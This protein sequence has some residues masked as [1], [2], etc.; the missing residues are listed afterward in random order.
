MTK[1]EI[2]KM[3]EITMID[4]Y[5]MH[6]KRIKEERDCAT[7]DNDIINT[8]YT[9]GYL[10]G[11]EREIEDLKNIIKILRSKEIDE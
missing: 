3:I 9:N 8:L 10:C 5:E 1:E 6:V 11:V 4:F 2:A 7:K